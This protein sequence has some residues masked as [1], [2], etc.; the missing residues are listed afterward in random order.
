MFA[1]KLIQSKRLVGFRFFSSFN[2]NFNYG[3]QIKLEN[4]IRSA[5]AKLGRMNE[6]IPQTDTQRKQKAQSDMK[7]FEA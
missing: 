6:I 1:K 3:S 7:E 5:L 4:D 2:S